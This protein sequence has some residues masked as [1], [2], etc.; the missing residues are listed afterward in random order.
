MLR[1]LSASEKPDP[2]QSLTAV[3][4]AEKFNPRKIQ[5]PPNISRTAIS[6]FTADE[7]TQLER[8]WEM[9][10]FSGNKSLIYVGSG[11]LDIV[12]NEEAELFRSDRIERENRPRPTKF[13][14]PREADFRDVIVMGGSSN[15]SMVQDVKARLGL[16]HDDPLIHGRFKDGEAK[17]ELKPESHISGKRIVYLASLNEPVDENIQELKLS[18][19]LLKK[20]SAKEIIL[21]LPYTGYSRQDNKNGNDHDPNSFAL[22]LKELSDIGGANLRMMF[23]DIHNP[24]ALGALT[25]KT[26]YNNIWASATYVPYIAKHYGKERIFIVAPDQGAEKRVDK[27]IKAL[28]KELKRLYGEKFI[29]SITKIVGTKLREE[30]NIV[31]NTEL[32]LDNISN[33]EGGVFFVLDDMIDTG[34]TAISHGLELRK[35]K[36]KELILC[37]VHGVFSDEAVERFRNSR[38]KTDDGIKRVFDRLILT[39]SIVPRRGKGDLMVVLELCDEMAHVAITALCGKGVSEMDWSRLP[40]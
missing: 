12:S 20:R 30:A 18:L 19:E 1:N 29:P 9:A 4:I 14:L 6:R 34:G 38:I 24:S 2:L 15:P 37:A 16:T 33:P 25:S 28:H 39:D 17:V 40:D 10:G 32:N 27:S 21:I 5:L 26:P 31:E 23:L 36:P 7:L 13:N 22:L 8:V 3:E 35:L 11:Q